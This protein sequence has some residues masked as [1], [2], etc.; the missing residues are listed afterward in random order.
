MP[1]ADKPLI[2]HTLEVFQASDVIDAVVLV[3]HRD[4][5]NDYKAIVDQYGLTKVKRVYYRWA[6]AVRIH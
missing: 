2:V 4:Y 1:V 3:I 6:N 5:A